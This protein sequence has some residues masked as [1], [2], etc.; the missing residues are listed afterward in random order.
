[1]ILRPMTGPG[2]SKFSEIN[3][4]KMDANEIVQ[5]GPEFERKVIEGFAFLVSDLGFDAPVIR[6]D[7]K[8]YRHTV[9][10]V[11]AAQNKR[12]ELENAY[13]PIDYGFEIKLYEADGTCRQLFHVLQQDQ[14][15][16]FQFLVTAAQ[17]LRNRQIV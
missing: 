6:S 16:A 5:L 3:S 13:H 2:N 4:T 8:K 12:L 7:P 11:H 15:R 9:E 17:T 14:D 10:Y 1:M